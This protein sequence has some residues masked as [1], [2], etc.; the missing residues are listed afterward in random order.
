MT[1]ATPPAEAARPAAAPAAGEASSPDGVPSPA[2]VPRKPVRWSRSYRLVPTRYPA[3][4]LFERVAPPEDWEALIELESMTNDRLRDEA[5]EISLVPA[6]DRVS[7]AGAS[8]VM[9]PFTHLAPEGGRF[10]TPAF[11]G[12]YAAR[13]IGTAVAETGWHRERFLA[14]TAEAPLEL[15][16]RLL[17]ARLAG[18][19]ADLRGLGAR[20]SALYAPED[21]SASQ[22]FGAGVRGAGGD[23]VVWDSVRE[24]GGRCAV[25]YRPRLVTGCREVRTLCYRWDGGRISE[26]YEKRAFEG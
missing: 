8:F 4:D 6:A 17:E 7:G 19:L 3:V 23:G 2:D 5:G 11:G 26:V 14:A 25:A 21:Y 10:T 9:A 12:Y 15:D 1:E 18:R 24:T 22:R 20:F 16:M 13:A